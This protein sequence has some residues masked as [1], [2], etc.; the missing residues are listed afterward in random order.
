[1]VIVDLGRV[2]RDALDA[3]DF[4]KRKVAED[5]QREDRALPVGKPCDVPLERRAGWTVREVFWIGGQCLLGDLF[6]RNLLP[7]ATRA[8]LRSAEIEGDLMNPGLEARL[9]AKARE[10]RVRL[11]EGR[12]HDFVGSVVVAEV[13]VDEGIESSLMALDESLEALEPSRE[14]LPDEL[15]VVQSSHTQA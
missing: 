12:L 9:A 3:S 7:R 15:A 10:L 8:E 14:R 13:S 11:H 5:P 2:F 6:K 1:M 4:P